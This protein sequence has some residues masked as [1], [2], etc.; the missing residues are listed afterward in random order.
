MASAGSSL[1]SPGRLPSRGPPDSSSEK[2]IDL[3]G[4]VNWLLCLMWVAGALERL[5][6][7]LSASVTVRQKL[8][9][10]SK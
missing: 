9:E 10:T 8:I 7:C 1:P 3:V 4:D 2:S 5:H 6:T